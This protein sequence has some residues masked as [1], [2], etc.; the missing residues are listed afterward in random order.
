MRQRAEAVKDRLY[1]EDGRGTNTYL[2]ARAYARRGWAVF[3]VYEAEA[4]GTCACKDRNCK[5]VG[6]HPRTPNGFKDATTH[7]DIIRDWWHR[8]PNANVGIAT[9]K[10]SGL[11][12]LDIDGADGWKS[13]DGVD[14]PP[15]TPRVHTGKV[16]GVHVYFAHPG[17]KISSKVGGRPGL[18]LKADGGYVVAPPSRHVSGARY[19]WLIPPDEPLAAAPPWLLELGQRSDSTKG[20]AAERPPDEWLRLLQGVPVGQRHDT[21]VRIAG[22]YLGKGWKP[23]EV[24]AL[25]L[26]FASQCDPPYVEPD[27]T[28]DIKRIV[29]DLVTKDAA[30]QEEGDS[31][32]PP[33]GGAGEESNF[34]PL[35]AR[36]ILGKDLEPI[37]WVWDS[38]LPEG[39]LSVLAAYM[40]VGKSTLAYALAV[41]IAQGRPFLDRPTKQGGVLILAV[42]EHP[43]DVH[44]RLVRF[45]MRRDDP[46][47]VQ[48]W[49]PA[50]PATYDRLRAF[51]RAN[52][53][54]L[55]VVDTLSTFWGIADENDNAQVGRNLT[56]LLNLARETGCVVLLV[57]HERKAGGDGG[58]GIRG[59]SALLALVDQA[60][61]LDRSGPDNRRVLRSLGR[62]EETPRDLVLELD[63]NNY[64][65]LGTPEDVGQDAAKRKVWDALSSVAQDVPTLAKKAGLTDNATR[66]AL[67]DLDE[68][69]VREGRGVK[70]DPHKY[71]RNAIPPQP[72]PKGE[73]S[74]L[75][76]SGDRSRK[77]S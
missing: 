48:G 61:T 67:K 7:L 54:R 52:A 25:L 17:S 26:G 32:P 69:V 50:T 63:G 31:F 11:L 24:E 21:A 9:G 5:K 29:C 2:A 74:N 8:W 70:G 44:R 34:R 3:P 18:D 57:H 13:L 43:R 72:S 71:R 36:D 53:I 6:K 46:L 64:R 75:S 15:S 51:V 35:S 28:E 60:L 58:R 42:E 62:Y 37:V 23:E 65:A 38:Y 47:F 66:K 39:V 22:H 12:V 76:A 59:G 16:R 10:A 33:K 45:G 40:K 68:E 20:R 55:V 30:K 77:L 19:E 73:E 49:L 27:E 56:P 1:L 41:A 14:L 4:D